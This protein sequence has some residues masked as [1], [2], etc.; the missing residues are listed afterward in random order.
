MDINCVVAI[1]IVFG[2][3]FDIEIP[4]VIQPLV[5]ANN[6]C[7]PFIYASANSTLK[8]ETKRIALEIIECSMQA[9]L[10]DKFSY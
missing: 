5:L 1:S 2:M 3:L 6:I 7:N 4:H 9:A 10:Q 8:A